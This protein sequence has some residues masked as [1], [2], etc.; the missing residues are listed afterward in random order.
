MA[1]AGGVYT[2]S[3]E[4]QLRVLVIDRGC[5]QTHV[6]VVAARARL[7]VNVL[8]P[9]GSLATDVHSFAYWTSM[10]VHGSGSQ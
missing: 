2:L 8:M 10:W 4:N 3:C 7:T 1:R 9:A 6:V 5:L